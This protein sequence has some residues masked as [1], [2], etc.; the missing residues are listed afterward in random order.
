[1]TTYADVLRRMVDNEVARRQCV[2]DAC[3]TAAA[4]QAAE[5]M[6]LAVRLG[7]GRPQ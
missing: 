5:E 4:K 2:D 3:R 1:M 6:D 7:L